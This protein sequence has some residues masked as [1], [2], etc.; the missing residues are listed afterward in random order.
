MFR[1]SVEIKHCLPVETFKI[2]QKLWE[3]SSLRISTKGTFLR[4][5]PNIRERRRYNSHEKIDQ[6]KVENDNP[7]DVEQARYKEFSVDRSIH[8]WGPLKE[9]NERRSSMRMT[10]TDTHRID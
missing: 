7:H 3:Q 6:P 1:V 8:H 9:F 2:A 10:C 5:S 4:R